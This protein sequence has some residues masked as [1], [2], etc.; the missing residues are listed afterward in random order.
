MIPLPLRSTVPASRRFL[1][2]L[3]TLAVLAL[4][5]WPD[6]A[7]AETAPA[8][9]ALP[10]GFD[11]PNGIAGGP[12]GGLFVGSVI[13]GDIL[14]IAPDGTV[15]RA[16]EETEDRFAGTALRFDPQSGLLWV[17]SPDFL[18]QEVNGER[19]RRP[20]RIAAV[21]VAE[22]RV[23]WSSAI[24]DEGFANDF[25][26]DGAGGIYITDSI[27]DRVLHLAGPGAAFETVTSDPL[28]APGALGPAGIARL[29]G[30]DL[31]VG[32]YSEGAL[33]R[34]RMGDAGAEVT[35][36]PLA[37]QIENPDGL[38]VAPDGRLLVL[39]GAVQSG[40]GR[41]LAIDLNAS[42]PLPVETL[43]EGLD[44][45]LNLTVV[46]NRVAVTEGRLRHFMLDDPSLG[47]PTSFRVVFVPLGG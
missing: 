28:F 35:P 12:Q 45:P 30:G 15:A 11:Y 2:A 25:A 13:S 44:M 32:L 26:L 37:R 18:G 17:A 46:G 21:D 5:G 23:V 36:L 9:I 29:G 16:F 1:P 43:A 41:L 42:A 7:L 6:A 22:G 20:H 3:L 40:N 39:E 38:A 31:V 8:D 19:V 33:L 47:V 4:P 14:R 24:P 10:Q 27:R 34:V